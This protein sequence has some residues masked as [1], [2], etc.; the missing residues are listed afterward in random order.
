MTQ[1]SFHFEKPEKLCLEGKQMA[2][3]TFHTS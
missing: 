1:F 3:G 2:H